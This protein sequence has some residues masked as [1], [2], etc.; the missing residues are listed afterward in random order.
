[1]LQRRCLVEEHD[2]ARR[3]VEK[4]RNNGATDGDVANYLERTK[5]SLSDND[6]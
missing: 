4:M 3:W 5:S 2:V 6:A 1:M